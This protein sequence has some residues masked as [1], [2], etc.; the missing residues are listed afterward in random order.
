M[1]V[2]LKINLH[3]PMH[4]ELPT[5]LKK[6]NFLGQKTFLT[7]FGTSTIKKKKAIEKKLA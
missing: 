2:T 1:A 5:A 6:R 4:F 3:A 7:D